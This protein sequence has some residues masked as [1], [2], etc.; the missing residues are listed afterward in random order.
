[1]VQNLQ[2]FSITEKQLN[3]HHIVWFYILPPP[4]NHIINAIT[5]TKVKK[6]LKRIKYLWF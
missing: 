1:M 5:I 3:S 6:S 4:T 2:V